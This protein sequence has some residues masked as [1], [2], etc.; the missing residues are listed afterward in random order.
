MSSQT[1]CPTTKFVSVVT[2]AV[3]ATMSMTALLWLHQKRQYPSLS[4]QNCVEKKIKTGQLSSPKDDSSTP[5]GCSRSS[6]TPDDSLMSSEQEAPLQRRHDDEEEEDYAESDDTDEEEEDHLHLPQHMEREFYKDERRR[7]MIPHLS[8]KKTMY[9]NI[10]MLDPNGNH[11]CNIS[12]KKAN[13]YINKNIATWIIHHADNNNNNNNN[14]NTKDCIQ[15]S[16]HPKMATTRKDHNL[17]TYNRG[18]K[19][20]QCVV[21]GVERDYMRHYVVPH[22]YRSLLPKSFKTHLPHDV[23]LLCAADCHVRAERRTHQRR[24]RMERKL[25]VDPET[26]PPQIVNRQLHH[27]QSSAQ[28]L[29]KWKDK[30]PAHRIVEYQNLL[31][32]WFHLDSI[33]AL[34]DQHLTQAS[35]IEARRPNPKYIPGPMLVMEHMVRQSSSSSSLDSSSTSDMRIAQF[36]RDWRLHFLQTM[37]PRFLPVGWSVDS[38]VQC[39]DRPQD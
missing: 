34:T 27:I 15:L 29:L 7:Q 9:D 8:M 25:R 30:L 17:V 24:M 37:Q 14:N 23:V 3:M 4:R 18:P 39:D 1:S 21:C 6:T 22:C 35:Q 2:V 5:P 20:N 31:V 26:E 33:D 38:P 11:L 13:W 10:R 36:V 16:F 19:V 28:A 32:D 12:M